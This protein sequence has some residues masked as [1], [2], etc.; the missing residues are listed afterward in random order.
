MD[1]SNIALDLSN[2]AES[3]IQA[4]FQLLVLHDQLSLDIIIKV[5]Q[6]DPNQIVRHEA[7]YCI[8]EFTEKKFHNAVD[9]LI[10][11]IETD[12]SEIVK[13]EAMLA[14]GN[15][16]DDGGM[17]ALIGF[18]DHN[19]SNLRITAEISLE[20]LIMRRQ[21]ESILNENLPLSHIILDLDTMREYRIQASFELLKIGGEQELEV[22]LKALHQETCPIVKHEIIFSLGEMVSS[23]II[24][25]LIDVLGKDSNPFVIHE[26]LLS[27]A[28]LGGENHKR[29]IEKYLGHDNKIISET[30]EIALKRLL[31]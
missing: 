17:K 18:I 7:A 24:P 16:G 10:E 15:L 9:A 5:L 22:L 26:S 23:D 30:A 21:K 3:K 2:S 1:H 28:N 12:K 13:H 4:I 29:I 14:L 25:A 8:G 27:L 11:A 20:R 6:N 31:N 19:N